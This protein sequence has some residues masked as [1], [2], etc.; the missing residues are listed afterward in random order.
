MPAPVLMPGQTQPGQP[1]ILM[2]L[3]RPRVCCACIDA[4]RR[5]GCHR[6]D[7]CCQQDEPEDRARSQYNSVRETLKPPIDDFPSSYQGFIKTKLNTMQDMG[8][9]KATSVRQI[10]RQ[11]QSFLSDSKHGS[12]SHRKKHFGN[13][14]YPPRVCWP[15][16]SLWTGGQG[17]LNSV[18][19]PLKNTREVPAGP[20]AQARAAT[21]AAPTG[22]AVIAQYLKTLPNSPGVY[23]MVDAEGTVIYVGKARN[24]K[25]RV[26]SYARAGTHTNRIAR[27]IA[28]TAAMEFVT[29]AHGGRGAAAGSQPDQAL[30]AALQRAAAGRQV[31]PLHSDGE[32][33]S[34]AADPQ[35]S[36]RAQP[37]GRLL[38]AVRLG[39]RR[40][41]HHQ[42]AGA[43][44]PAAVV[45]GSRVREP[46]AAVPAAPDQALLGAMHRRDR[47]RGVQRAGRG[48]R[49]LPA[50]RKPERARRCTSA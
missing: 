26:T 18:A 13:T 10:S 41:P 12:T 50:R 46:H 14:L 25:A 27:M 22:P 9:S 47:P 38:R 42:H 48:G 32:R 7:E 11:T 4:K 3:H 15:H 2:V 21:G 34:G 30:P 20:A 8:P 1:A 24:L 31:V 6:A 29:R 16:S 44:V 36:R 19:M 5:E 39:R 17:C 43:G 45:L 35:A 49:A 33:A 40:Q 28:A 23:R 37:Q